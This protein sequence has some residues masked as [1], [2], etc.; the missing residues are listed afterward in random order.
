[1]EQNARVGTAVWLLSYLVQSVVLAYEGSESDLSDRSKHHVMGN[2]VRARVLSLTQA[3]GRQHFGLP[4]QGE[5]LLITGG[6]LGS[7]DLN[8]ACVEALKRM[9]GD[10][11]LKE[12]LF[13]LFHTGEHH[14]SWV[15]EALRDS[16]FHIQF[17]PYIVPMPEAL[18]CSDLVIA[19][20]GAM[21]VAELSARGLPAILLPW[22]GAARDHQRINCETLASQGGAIMIT[23]DQLSGERLVQELYPLLLDSAARNRMA[24]IS[25]RAGRP[26]AAMDVAALILDYAE[27]R[28]PSRSLSN[29][30]SS[31][32]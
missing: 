5:V 20:G 24:E 2:P 4:P 3:E 15:K 13:V 1:L 25:R 32:D 7:R 29:H 22:V 23:A 18:A 12:R 14:L 30:A 9:E 6:S 10:D 19:R 17:H 27:K 28:N 21:T 11:V 8:K 16:P 31:V 26:H